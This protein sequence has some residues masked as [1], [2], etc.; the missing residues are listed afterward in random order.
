MNAG[1][2]ASLW[3]QISALFARMDMGRAITARE[4][5]MLLAL[6]GVCA[7]SLA[8]GALP[9]RS[10]LRA[11]SAGL[12]ALG[13]GVGALAWGAGLWTAQLWER[14]QSLTLHTVLWLLLPF[15]H[16]IVFDP[17]AAVIGTEEFMVEVAREGIDKAT[18]D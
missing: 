11:R 18:R 6:G 1:C 4:L 12:L 15:S 9:W 2:Y 10:L 3:W 8:W 17:D 5:A 13:L 16:A 7:L 14:L